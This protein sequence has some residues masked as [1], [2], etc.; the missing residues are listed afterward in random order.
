MT[1]NLLLP[2]KCTPLYTD[3]CFFVDWPMNIIIDQFE[4]FVCGLHL[5]TFSLNIENCPIKNYDN[6]FFCGRMKKGKLADKLT[7]LQC[8]CDF[9]PKILVHRL[10][11]KVRR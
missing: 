9:M 7:L 10:R 5:A 4:D 1:N 11:S 3:Y 6:R 2:L 8:E